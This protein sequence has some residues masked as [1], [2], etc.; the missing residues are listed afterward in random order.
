MLKNTMKKNIKLI[1]AQLID[2]NNHDLELFSSHYSDDIK[3]YKGHERELYLSGI[4]DFKSIYKERFSNPKLHAEII[5]R[6]ELNNIVIDHERVVGLAEEP[7][8]VIAI[9]KIQNQKISEVHFLS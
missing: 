2:Y 7:V 6:I 3:I 4:K 1:E 5:N 8:E 9:Y